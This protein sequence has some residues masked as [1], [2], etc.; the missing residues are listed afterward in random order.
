M[1][2][3]PGAFQQVH[4]ELFPANP[5]KLRQAKLRETPKAF[6]P[7]DVVLTPGEFVL[8]VMYP[9]VSVSFGDQA[10]IGLP[11]IRLDS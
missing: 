4:D 3:S 2:E 7:V 9:M 10:V 11:A 6:D 1:V 8:M 5:T